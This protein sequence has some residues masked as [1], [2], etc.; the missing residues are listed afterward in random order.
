VKFS[1]DSSASYFLVGYEDKPGELRLSADGT[2]I[3]Q[4]AD[5][6]QDAHFS[7]D[8]GSTYFVIDNRDEL[9]ELRR[10]ADG[11]LISQLTGEVANVFFDSDP[12][13]SHMIVD[14]YNEPGELRKLEGGT[15]IYTFED[16]IEQAAFSPDE[17][18]FFVVYS[19]QTKEPR[20]NRDQDFKPENQKYFELHKTSNGVIV[21]FKN[22]ITKITFFEDYFFVN[23]SDGQREMWKFL[24]YPKLIADLGLGVFGNFLG[25]DGHKLATF[26]SDGTLYI[27]DLT[28]LGI[29]VDNQSRPIPEI[30][31][32]ACDELFAS[33]N[34][35]INELISY[36]GNVS[37]RGCPANGSKE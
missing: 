9:D 36:L 1:P 2:I 6:F 27:S 37:P 28:W 19:K 31:G 23:Y 5:D 22:E 11:S 20:F 35:D 33:E 26:Y 32:L 10:T 13:S 21:P 7:T 18:Y 8:T 15:I 29:I 17:T 25:S 4:L 14:Y 30:I 16:D 24:D 34:F 12:N 3:A